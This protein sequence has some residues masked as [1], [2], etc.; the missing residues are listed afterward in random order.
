MLLRA[1]VPSSQPPLKATYDQQ[2]PQAQVLEF[3]AA[4][5]SAQDPQAAERHHLVNRI[6]DLC[7]C[8]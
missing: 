4:S 2:Q 6:D 1:Y 3:P 8:V 7:D 5:N